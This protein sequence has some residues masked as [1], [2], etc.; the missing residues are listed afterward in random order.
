MLAPFPEGLC[1]EGKGGNNA[2]EREK[3]SEGVSCPS[4]VQWFGIQWDTIP[5][6]NLITSFHT[7]FQM[8]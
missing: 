1:R 2:G 3:W 4:T 5:N 7:R 8:N 6:K